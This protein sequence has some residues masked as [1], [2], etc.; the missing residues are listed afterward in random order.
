MSTAKIANRKI[1]VEAMIP[2]P[3]EVVWQRTQQPDLHVLWDIRFNTIRYL[4][5]KDQRGFNVMDYRT[6]I[7]FGVEVAG[8]GHYLQ[9]IPLSLS[10]FE[11]DSHDWKSLITLGRGIWLYQPHN[12]ATYFKTVYDYQV[13]HGFAGRFVDY[14][15]FRN[16]IRLATEWGFETLRL[17]CMGDDNAVK[18]RR[19]QI[20]FLA[21]YYKRMCGAGAKAGAARSWLGTG[22][23]SESSFPELQEPAAASAVSGRTT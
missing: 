5:R 20:R 15:F 17:W 13:R 3:V 4:E 14:L 11:F 1:V 6:R 2:A 9:S 16:F 22:N 7:G 19:S 21:F 8:F 23:A 18:R 12:N 10:T